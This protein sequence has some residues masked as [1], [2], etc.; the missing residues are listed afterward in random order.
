M[1]GFLSDAVFSST[2]GRVVE[3]SRRSLG[4]SKLRK[5]TKIIG[6]KLRKKETFVVILKIGLITFFSRGGSS[7]PS[8]SLSSSTSDDISGLLRGTR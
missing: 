2:A 1:I 7:S 8:S 6:S 5:K 4:Q 3:L